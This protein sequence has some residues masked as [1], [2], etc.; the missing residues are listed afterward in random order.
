MPLRGIL[1]ATK[2]IKSKK[3]LTKHIIIALTKAPQRGP[4]G[5]TNNYRASAVSGGQE[6]VD[7]AMRDS[8]RREMAKGIQNDDISTPA[9]ELC[10]V[11]TYYLGCKTSTTRC[12]IF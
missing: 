5:T 7:I 8:E 10:L 12:S 3:R 4:H 1:S 2:S 11:D 9:R 6:S